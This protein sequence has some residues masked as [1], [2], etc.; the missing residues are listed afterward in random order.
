MF[1]KWKKKKT[2]TIADDKWTDFFPDT[3]PLYT[4]LL[5]TSKFGLELYTFFKWRSIRDWRVGGRVLNCTRKRSEIRR[6]RE[7]ER[8]RKR[9]WGILRKWSWTSWIF[10]RLALRGWWQRS[11]TVTM[12]RMHREDS[13]SRAPARVLSRTDVLAAKRAWS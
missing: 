13:R 7:R 9:R 4:L 6:E 2:K 5:H 10:W 12:A 3:N 1:E 11:R 8:E